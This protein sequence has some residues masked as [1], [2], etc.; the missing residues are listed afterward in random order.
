MIEILHY[1]RLLV[2]YKIIQQAFKSNAKAI[3]KAFKKNKNLA[4][5][6][7]F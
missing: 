1:M 2:I 7:I 5:L 6:Y 4:V 3:N